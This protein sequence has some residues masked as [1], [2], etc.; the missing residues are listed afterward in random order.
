[1]SPYFPIS[2]RLTNEKDL[3]WNKRAADENQKPT[4]KSKQPL[5]FNVRNRHTTYVV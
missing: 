4:V 1:M 5:A 2:S 3:D